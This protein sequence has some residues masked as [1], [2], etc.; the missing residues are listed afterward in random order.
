VRPN[1]AGRWKSRLQSKRKGRTKGGWV[2][3]SLLGDPGW[4]FGKM[5]GGRKVSELRQ[6]EPRRAKKSILGGEGMEP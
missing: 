4:V 3:R 5:E 6:P 2:G 1:P